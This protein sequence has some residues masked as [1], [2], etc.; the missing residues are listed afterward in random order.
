MKTI[1]FLAVLFI[2]AFAVAACTEETADAP[3]YKVTVTVPG[4]NGS[5]SAD[6]TQAEAGATVILS[7]TPD[8][9]FLFGS[10]K[11]ESGDAIIPDVSENPVEIVMP[12]GDITVSASFVEEKL[13]HA[14]TVTETENGSVAVSDGLTQ[15]VEGESVTVTAT[16]DE[17]YRFVQWTVEGADVA[18]DALVANPLTFTMPDQEVTVSAEFAEIIDVLAETRA[19]MEEVTAGDEEWFQELWDDT[20]LYFEESMNNRANIHNPLTGEEELQMPWDTDG[21]GILTDVEASNVKI[22]SLSQDADYYLETLYFVRYFTGLEVLACNGMYEAFQGFGE[23]VDLSRNTGLKYIDLAWCIDLYVSTLVLGDKPELEYLNLQGTWATEVDLSVCP[24][25]KYLNISS[26][27][28][29]ELDITPLEATSGWELVYDEG[30][31][32]KVIL[33]ADQ[34][35]AFREAYPDQSY[36]VKG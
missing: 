24:K 36:E 23:L 16:P 10:W 27:D 28:I 19:Y 29:V 21:D 20:F 11:V 6:V 9:G 18:Q 8:E 5:A 32:E 34:E 17:G 15:A 35:E 12:A 2:A 14:I 22:I 4:G 33:R 26:T 1:R 31:L 3:V 30:Y 25:L 13:P 7:A